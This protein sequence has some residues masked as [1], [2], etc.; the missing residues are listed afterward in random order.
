MGMFVYRHFKLE[1]NKIKW[2]FLVLLFLIGSSGIWFGAEFKNIFVPLYVMPLFCLIINVP[3]MQWKGYFYL[4]KISG[5]MYFSHLL[6]MWLGVKI[7]NILYK[8]MK[9][10]IPLFIFTV[11]ISFLFGVICFKLKNNNMHLRD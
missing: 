10:E 9:P 2:K 11:I 6:F 1:N 8:G 4:R 7:V 3:E 5:Y